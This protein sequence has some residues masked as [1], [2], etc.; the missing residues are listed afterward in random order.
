MEGPPPRDSSLLFPRISDWNGTNRLTQLGFDSELSWLLT[1]IGGLL[2]AATLVV[3][4]AME[5]A[6]SRLAR[7]RSIRTNSHT[8]PDFALRPPRTMDNGFEPVVNAIVENKR[9]GG[10]CMGNRLA[11]SILLLGFVG[12]G[13]TLY[14]A[15]SRRRVFPSMLSSPLMHNASFTGTYLLLGPHSSHLEFSLL[16]LVCG[17]SNV[18]PLD[19]ECMSLV[20][21]QASPPA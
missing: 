4:R 2:T 6:T 11:E 19:G 20:Q 9:F 14:L 10:H 3:L 18:Q 15:F 21:K 12:I 8:H 5:L 7:P 1:L 13:A 17:F 16:V